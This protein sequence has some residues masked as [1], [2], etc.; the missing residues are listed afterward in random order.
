M[1]A[2]RVKLSIR[3]CQTKIIGQM[4][5]TAFHIMPRDHCASNLRMPRNRIPRMALQGKRKQADLNSPDEAQSRKRLKLWLSH[6]M[7]RK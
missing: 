1:R 2:N 6:G 3:D 4:F 7:M 5:H